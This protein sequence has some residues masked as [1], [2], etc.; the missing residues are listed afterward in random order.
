MKTIR[1]MGRVAAATVLAAGLAVWPA[2]P[3][4]A[5]CD[6]MNG[7]VILE[8]K[9]ALEQGDVTPVLKWVPAQD[10]AEISAV[11]AHS[12][13]VRATGAEARELADRYFF[14]TLVRVHRRSEGAPY[15]GIN[16]QPV[17]PVVAMADRSVAEG[18]ADVMIGRM[19]AHLARAVR[20]KLERVVLA[21]GHKDDSV[22]AGREY[23][24]AYVDYV[25]FAEGIHE[26]IAGAGGHHA[27]AAEGAAKHAH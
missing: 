20:E 7:P 2:G 27:E 8:A 22:A 1:A 19:N 9:T 25:H 3:A 14:E 18:S 10:E 4:Q 21:A 17:A 15:T 23:V 24:A 26:A 5:H 13:A 11:F 16:D 6:S 12:M